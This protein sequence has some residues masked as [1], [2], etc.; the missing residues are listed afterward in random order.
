MGKHHYGV[1]NGYERVNK[2]CMQCIKVETHLFLTSKSLGQLLRQTNRR[3]AALRLGAVLL[4][5]LEDRRRPRAP[6]LPAIKTI[7]EYYYR[8]LIFFFGHNLL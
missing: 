2:V 6:N 1:M 7:R 4:R 5:C 8:K 3:G